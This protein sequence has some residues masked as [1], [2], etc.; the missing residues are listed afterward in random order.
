MFAYAVFSLWSLQLAQDGDV[1][2]KFLALVIGKVVR[3]RDKS[4]PGWICFDWCY[5]DRRYIRCLDGDDSWLVES[6]D[7]TFENTD[8]TSGSCI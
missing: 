4:E 8:C 1:K 3:I 5:E 6:Q 2:I 7:G